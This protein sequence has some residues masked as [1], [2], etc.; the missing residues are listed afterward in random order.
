MKRRIPAFAVL[1]TLLFSLNA[2]QNPSRI[3]P[4][5]PAPF[6]DLSVSLSAPADVPGVV[7]DLPDAEQAGFYALAGAEVTLVNVEGDLA[8]ALSASPVARAVSDA[9]GVARFTALRCGVDYRI[10]V[11]V[12][13]GSCEQVE[14]AVR[15]QAGQTASCK[16]PVEKENRSAYSGDIDIVENPKVFAPTDTLHFD[17][18]VLNPTGTAVTTEWRVVA[19]ND[20]GNV[21]VSGT[22]QVAADGTLFRPGI[23]LVLSGLPPTNTS[24]QSSYKIL[25]VV[26]GQ[27]VGSDNFVILRGPAPEPTATAVPPT[28]TPVPPTATPTPIEPIC[29]QS[30]T[31]DLIVQT[32]ANA[33]LI[34]PALY[35]IEW[36]DGCSGAPWISDRV[37][38]RFYGQDYTFRKVVVLPP[39][40]WKASAQVMSDD[41]YVFRLGGQA[42][43]PCPDPWCYERCTTF[44]YENIPGGPVTIEIEDVDTGAWYYGVNYNV[45]FTPM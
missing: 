38:G 3:A 45:C 12:G 43:Q 33:V 39:G 34:D 16:V 19:A 25:C 6:G 44:Q 37:D 28:A 31:D 2:C 18:E 42:D 4:V 27:V 20:P 7:P 30:G 1:M 26:E 13:G 5:G 21:L 10:L 8:A 32:G 11:N 29:V 22:S 40:N 9:R 24:G 36:M 23:P 17:W 35:P 14:K 15:T 41:W